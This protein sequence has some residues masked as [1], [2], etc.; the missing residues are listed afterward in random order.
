MKEAKTMW[1]FA[2]FCIHL[3]RIK[4]YFY[5]GFV[6]VTNTVL[7]DV[8]NTG[9]VVVVPSVES[10]QFN[11][12][13]HQPNDRQQ[14]G[15]LFFKF[16]GMLA[17]VVST[18]EQELSFGTNSIFLIPISWWSQGMI[19]DQTEVWFIKSL[20]Q[21][22]AKIKGIKKQS[23]LQELNSLKDIFKLSYF[24][25]LYI[26]EVKLNRFCDIVNCLDFYLKG[27]YKNVWFVIQILTLFN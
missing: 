18:L 22:V 21:L 25:S 13:I 14:A 2:K 27:W 19:F 6:D 23:L 15:K 26:F 7:V 8:T 9:L 24:L 1:I 3:L 12:V 10:A 16:P 4:K 20:Q 5:L 17:K 11:H